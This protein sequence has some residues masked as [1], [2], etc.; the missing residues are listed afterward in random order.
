MHNRSDTGTATPEARTRVKWPLAS[1]QIVLFPLFTWYVSYLAYPT[2]MF[3]H[4]G[5]PLWSIVST[6]VIAST[7]ALPVLYIIGSIRSGL[8]PMTHR[9]L[10]RLYWS[11]AVL[12][13]GP[14]FTLVYIA[15]VH[16]HVVDHSFLWPLS[17]VGAMFAFLGP[18]LVSSTPRRAAV[19]TAVAVGLAV[20][21]Y[22]L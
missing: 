21:D 9:R 8:F 18:A 22:V 16:N 4:V 7:L 3:M 2:L 12:V 15:H 20:V 10:H 6:V 11:A 19:I 5:D 1:A 17:Y 13:Q 14:A